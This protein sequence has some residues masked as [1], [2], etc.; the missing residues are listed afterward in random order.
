[1]RVMVQTW[2]EQSVDQDLWSSSPS[3]NRPH[4]GHTHD[5]NKSHHRVG[6]LKVDDDLWSDFNMNSGYQ[7]Y[8]TEAN[9]EDQY[10]ALPDGQQVN[11]LV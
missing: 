7:P 1:M 5:A 6:Q 10:E 2:K 4:G 11:V 8:D 3:H 9:Y